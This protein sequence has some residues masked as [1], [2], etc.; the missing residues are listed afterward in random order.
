VPEVSFDTVRVSA[1]SQRLQL[2]AESRP[3]IAVVGDAVVSSEG[4][5]TT[6]EPTGRLVIRV[7]EG[8]DIVVGTTS[9]R[10]ALNGQLGH[11][12]VV[13]QSGRVEVG[14]AASVD[15]RTGSG[16]VV[17]GQCHGECRVHTKS[18][19]VEVGSC[20][21][22]DVVARSGRI[23]LRGVDGPARAH[24]VSG[25]IDIEMRSPHDVE[26]E[27]VSGRITVSLP[28]GC[29]YTLRSAGDEAPPLPGDC[30]VLARSVSG[31]VA[32]TT[33]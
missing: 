15:I 30:V 20:D 32:V 6:I 1:T 23:V 4:T 13:S 18:G 2:I 5:T 24:C 11:V 27:T 17:V 28:P 7:P 14:R 26:A 22:A 8:T 29:G 21:R 19:R 10:V 33:R 25:R 12:A 16:R 3:D 9:G 31:R